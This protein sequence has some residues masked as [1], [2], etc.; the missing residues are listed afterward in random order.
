[1][2]AEQAAIQCM[3]FQRWHAYCHP[4]CAEVT[5]PADTCFSHRRSSTRASASEA[6][7]YAARCYR[8]PSTHLRLRFLLLK[9]YMWIAHLA[10][11]CTLLVLNAAECHSSHCQ[12]LNG[13]EVGTSE[14]QPRTE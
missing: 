12:K 6:A 3:H 8:K 5:S 9:E 14:Y 10:E 4:R 7:E 11:T 1:M 13:I 2:P